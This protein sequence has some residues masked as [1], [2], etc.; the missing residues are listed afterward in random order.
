MHSYSNWIKVWIILRAYAYKS[1]KEINVNYLKK[2]N[3][4]S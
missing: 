3:K 2:K 1:N 4:V